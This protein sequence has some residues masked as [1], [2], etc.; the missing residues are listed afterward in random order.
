[1]KPLRPGWLAVLAH[2]VMAWL[3]CA[4]V[5]VADA[6]TVNVWLTTADQHARLEP[7]GAVAFASAGGADNPVRVDEAV[8]FQ[9]IEGFGGSFT[10][11]SAYLLNRVATP[12]ARTEAMRRLFTREGEGIGLSFV[13][14]PIG[15]CDYAR[16]HYTYDDVA[17]G[18]EDQALANFSIAHDLEDIVPLLQQART[19]NPQLTIMASPWSP[20]AWMK[21]SGSLI[22]GALRAEAAEAFANYLVKYVQAYAA[23]GLPTHYL[24]LQNEPLYEP[25][26][27]PGMRMDAATQT[28]L[29]RDRVLPAFAANG[30]TTKLLI[31]DHNWDRP[32]YPEAVFADATLRASPQIAGTAWHGYGGTPGVMEDL[33]SRYSDK[34]NY[35]TEHSGGTWIADQMKAD[36][37]EITLSLRSSARAY[38]KWNLALDERRGPFTAGSATSTCSALLTVHST[39]G[40][41]T[42]DLEYYTL[43]HFSR[44]ILPGA[45]RVLSTNAVGIITAA[46]VNPDDS[47][48]LVAYNDSASARTF[49]V[50]WGARQF[51]YTLAAG[52]G[53]TFTWSG[54]VSG[55][56][57]A[58]DAKAP[59]LASNSSE[60]SGLQA[61]SC[62]DVQGG[63]DLGYADGGDY[64]VYR[65]LD[66]GAGV[67]SV[68][69]RVASAG[70]GGS[71]EFRLDSPSGA[72][73]AS[74]A[75]PTTG[76]W[77]AWQTVT[78]A[79][80]NVTG[81]R[82]VYVVFA[83]GNSIG[84]LNWFQFSADAVPSA[85]R[86][87]SEAYP[88]TVAAGHGVSFSVATSATPAA[89]YQWQVSSNNGATW[90][91]LSDDS[92]YSGSGTSTLT[93]GSVTAAVSGRQYRAVATNPAGTT[94]SEVFTLTVIASSFP[95][96]NGVAMDATGTRWIADSSTNTIARFP[97]AGVGSI[98]AGTN[99]QQGA[100][101]GVGAA[102]RFRQPSGMVLGTAG[103]I[104][105]AD[106]G[107]SLIRRITSDGTVTTLAGSATNQ[108]HRDGI[109]VAA[110]FNQPAALARDGAGNLFVADTGNALVR[111]I[112]P[113]GT[114]TTL[115]GT[116]G[117]R[118]SAD[119]SGAAAQFNQPSGIA[120][121][122]NGTLYVADTLNQTIRK[123]TPEGFVSTW[124]GLAG[125][126]GFADGAGAD[127]LF[128][129]PTGLTLDGA[130]NLYVADTGN[131]AIRKI[132]PNGTV[133][134]L[135]GL[136]GVAGLQDGAG[137]MAWFN[138]PKDVQFDG[139]ASLFVADTGNATLRKVTLDGAVVTW[140]LRLEADSGGGGGNSGGGGS[141]GDTTPPPSSG[142]GG[143]GGGGGAISLPMLLALV[144]LAAARR[145]MQS[146]RTLSGQP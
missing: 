39:T 44:F 60:L 122:A 5:G 116:A 4:W 43:G 18:T 42:Y 72:R 1:M 67:A 62:Q 78:A 87:T 98:L 100:T 54:A 47:K 16:S 89:S 17:A 132:A 74:V 106:T 11:A 131:S 19:L 51:G 91:N 128:N 15:S 101:D 23:Q 38:V 76:G 28:A 14:N 114:V 69:A 146:R 123:I 102:A 125:V 97:V 105:V 108:G 48:V 144:V 117:V 29:L 142:G 30:L 9:T 49:Q 112:A 73:I 81:V 137:S 94:T 145:A 70:G 65:G 52:A 6:Q 24:S 82:D 140:A 34:G 32:D 99:G 136:P 121:A 133:T 143:G 120:V 66:F 84:N 31:Y 13:R 134:T 61:E 104:Y 10:D 12:D 107:N 115:A 46:F 8:R 20:P 80:E 95:S 130:G 64:A 129:Q 37:S 90:T 71:I 53:A 109:G 59:V 26:N 35:V 138:Q 41:V 110:W 111:K 45:R 40:A 22:A 83:G 92:T 141:G 77:Q 119:G 75:V 36:F 113:D 127:A 7:Q 126:S 2:S 118:G 79:A 139:V 57:A 33:A 3:S 63:Y 68:S 103:T 85:P 124:A 135:A 88:Q 93:L 86:F 25:S 21:T 58:L 56:A 27:Y 96:P 55:S 50:Q